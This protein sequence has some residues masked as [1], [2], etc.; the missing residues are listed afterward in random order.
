M[1]TFAL[2]QFERIGSS[3]YDGS[4]I[5]RSTPLANQSHHPPTPSPS[6]RERERE[7]ESGEGSEGKGNRRWIAA[8]DPSCGSDGETGRGGRVKYLAPMTSPLLISLLLDQELPLS[9]SAG[10]TPACKF[11]FPLS[12]S[13]S[14]VINLTM[15][16]YIILSLIN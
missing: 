6:P 13:L 12:L 7:R 1:G 15:F 9:F 14:L 11:Q 10:K 2:T 4:R 16:S 5:L 8:W 3:T